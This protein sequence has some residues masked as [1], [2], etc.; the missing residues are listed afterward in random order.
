MKFSTKFIKATQERCSFTHPVNAPYFR[1]EFQL[2]FTPAQ[3]EITICGLGFYELWINGIKITKGPLAPYICNPDHILP[4]DRYEITTLLQPGK[5][6]IGIL[7]GNGFRNA[8]G[9]FVWDFDKAACQGAPTVALCLEATDGSTNVSIECDE[10]FLTHPSPILRD[11]LRMG[12]HYDANLE[13][14]GWNTP[15]FDDSTWAP[16]LPELTPR[17]EGKLCEAEPIRVTQVLEPVSCRFFKQTHIAREN[18]AP[19]ATPLPGSLRTN[20][21]LFDFG[22]NDAGVTQ[23]KINGKKGQKIKIYHGEHL[24]NGE[25]CLNTISFFGKD[26]PQFIVDHYM[27]DNQ[28][29]VFICK[30]GEETFVPQFKYDGFQYAL[31]EGLEPDQLQ[32]D[33]LRFLVMHS[34]LPVRAAFS[35]SDPVLNRLQENT[36]RSDLSNFYYFPTDCPHREKNG[37]TGDI[38]LSAEHILLNLKAE[39]SL[40]EWLLQLRRAQN[41][42]GAPPSILPTGGWRFGDGPNWDSVCIT[43]PYQ[44]YRF[45]GSKKVITD[46]LHTMMRYLTYLSTHRN[47]QGLIEEGLGDWLDPFAEGYKQY[48]SPLA[49]TSSIASFLAAE[50]AAFLMQEAGCTLEATYAKSLSV[51]LKNS[52]R[53]HLLDTSTMTVAGDCQTSQAFALCAGI[54]TPEEW[55]QA[56][57][58]L[59]EIVRRDGNISTCGIIGAR[60]LYHALESVGATELAYELITN[61]TSRTCYGYWIEHGATT[62]WENFAPVDGAGVASR[63]HHFAGDISSFFIQKIA[64]LQP[65]PNGNDLHKFRFQPYFL[66][67]LT[68][69]EAT[70]DSP[71]GRVSIHWERNGNAVTVSLTLPEGTCG[72]LVL[73][74]QTETFVTSGK[75][76]YE[77]REQK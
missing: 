9:G 73:P 69:A 5:N 49:V 3:G 68:F 29:D 20:V 34:D 71:S 28:T 31:V 44:L 23:L 67:A 2:D 15:G 30:G 45:T 16:A 1:K 43:L 19:N 12:Y 37:W 51:A 61:Q 39:K 8:F 10:S 21:Y 64:G 59:I 24:V 50:E 63:N 55:E 72:T 53:T 56:G 32:P 62:L 52:I 6:V 70:F 27:N 35:C 25:F 60:Y 48:A 13:L 76:T 33:T 57:K 40:D 58:R 54:F 18:T 74:G 41:E 66:K 17:G 4:Y 22:V 36:R 75:H 42:A 11:D 65:N 47:E 26:R 38:N 7:L 14:P 46:N 77:W